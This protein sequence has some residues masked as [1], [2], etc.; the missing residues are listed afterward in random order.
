MN[1]GLNWKPQ[2]TKRWLN[3]LL[4]I[5]IRA[6]PRLSAAKCIPTRSGH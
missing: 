3:F 4:F 2:L 5:Q 1:A 6:H